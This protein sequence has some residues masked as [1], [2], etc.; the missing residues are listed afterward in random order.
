MG[1]EV[2]TVVRHGTSPQTSSANRPMASRRGG[3]PDRRQTIMAVA[4]SRR[5]GRGSRSPCATP[6]RCKGRPR[7]SCANCSGSRASRPRRSSP[8]GC[9]PTPLRRRNSAYRLAM[10]KACARRNYNWPSRGDA[11]RGAVSIAGERV[12]DRSR[13]ESRAAV[14]LSSGWHW[15]RGRPVPAARGFPRQHGLLDEVPR[16]ISKR[17][18]DD[19]GNEK[20]SPGSDLSAYQRGARGGRRHIATGTPNA[21]SRA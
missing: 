7:S 12:P 14:R 9:A 1:L 20:V 4:S 18:G 21:P 13:G 8:I 17:C 10:S 16:E 6:P 19:Y 11:T 15:G 3:G 2:W 5:R